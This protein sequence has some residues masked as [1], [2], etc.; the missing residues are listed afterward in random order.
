[1][2]GIVA[3][4]TAHPAAQVVGD[5]ECWHAAEVGHGP[6]VA[7]QPV[8]ERLGPGGLGEGVI[9]GA[10]DGDKELRRA[11]LA[12]GAVHHRH[13]A[14]G[15]IHKA[16]LPGRVRLAHGALLPAEPVPVAVAELGVAVT[17]AR[18]ALGV[19]LPHQPLGHMRT[20]EFLVHRGP[21]RDL[22]ARTAG[23]IGAGIETARPGGRHRTRAATAR[24]GPGP[25]P[26]G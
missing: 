4:G 11:Y 1:M 25:G 3:A 26:G 21:V 10:Q 5:D 15:V 24:P 22:A 9:G 17:P 2:S 6:G 12:R 18:V 13:G 14:A 7:A 19:F 20:S 8:G 16:L 23:A